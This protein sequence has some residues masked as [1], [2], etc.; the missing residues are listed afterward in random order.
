MRRTFELG[1]FVAAGILIAFG[2]GAIA[3]GFNGRSTVHSSLNQ[4]QIVGTPDMTPKALGPRVTP[5]DTSLAAP[6]A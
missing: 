1:G 5:A 4:E 3:M 2:I 6:V